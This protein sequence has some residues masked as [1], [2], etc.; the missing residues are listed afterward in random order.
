MLYPNVNCVSFGQTSSDKVDLP[1][2]FVPP[3]APAKPELD[4]SAVT[5]EAANAVEDVIEEEQWPA[6]YNPIDDPA[7]YPGLYFAKGST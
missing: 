7:N 4:V 3:P 5:G 2:T 1:T 6:V